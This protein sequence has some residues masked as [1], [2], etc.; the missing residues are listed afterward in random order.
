MENLITEKPILTVE[1]FEKELVV[2]FT[3]ADIESISNSYRN[4]ITVDDAA[5]MVITFGKQIAEQAEANPE[6]AKAVSKWSSVDKMLFMV[7]EA[8]TLGA[9]HATKTTAAAIA[10]A[11]AELLKNSEIAYPIDKKR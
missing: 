1:E 7:R 4:T 8:Y 9:V 10:H 6:T 11:A 3:P 5:E 2:D